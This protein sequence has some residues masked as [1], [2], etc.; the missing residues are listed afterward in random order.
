MAHRGKVR[1]MREG[2]REAVAQR[3]GGVWGG[4][5]RPE[6]TRLRVGVRMVKGCVAA[7]GDTG[8]GPHRGE[9]GREW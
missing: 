3:G 1:H 2:S 9:G 4:A 7:W 8:E 5:H 6:A